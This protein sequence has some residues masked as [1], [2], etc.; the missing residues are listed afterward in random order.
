MSKKK[1]TAQKISISQ[2]FLENSLL[3]FATTIT[4]G[5]VFINVTTFLDKQKVLG[6]G[7]EAKEVVYSPS[8]D[9]EKVFWGNLIE[10]HPSF[11]DGYLELADIEMKRGN[12]LRAT[13]LINQ[14]KRIDPNSLEIITF[15]EETLK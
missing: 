12:K 15:E 1:S 6:I 5:V 13:N 4:L 2:R 14:A 3:A 10:N 8:L 7:A 9:D 11:R